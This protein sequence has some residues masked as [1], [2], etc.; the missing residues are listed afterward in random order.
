MFMCPVVVCVCL[1]PSRS[2]NRSAGEHL[3]VRLLL[4][5]PSPLFLLRSS[6][7]FTPL[8]IPPSV[9]GQTDE[10]KCQPPEERERDHPVTSIS[11]AVSLS[12]D[13]TLSLAIPRFLLR[14][15]NIFTHSCLVFS[16]QDLAISSCHLPLDSLR[17]FVITFLPHLRLSVQISPSFL[18]LQFLRH[19]PSFPIC[20]SLVGSWRAKGQPVADVVEHERWPP[21]NPDT[22]TYSSSPSC[23][24]SLSWTWPVTPTCCS[25][26]SVTTVL[27]NVTVADFYVSPPSPWP[28]LSLPVLILTSV[29]PF[30]SPHVSVH[31]RSTW[32]KTG[33]N[34]GEINHA[35]GLRAS[36]QLKLNSHS[37]SFLDRS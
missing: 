8:F 18:P 2:P 37:S 28:R 31:F 5:L 11:P 30:T 10:G 20:L 33:S 1:S 12:P 25:C 7:S 9:T 6:R 32:L 4:I 22:R 14:S 17:S 19:S 24:Q 15:V 3:D 21:I 13:C 34:L 26:P 35:D 16:L 29:Y 36:Q 23:Q 27:R